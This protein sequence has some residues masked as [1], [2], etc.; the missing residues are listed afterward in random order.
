MATQGNLA[1]AIVRRYARRL[2]ARAPAV[3]ARIRL[4]RTV[5]LADDFINEAFRRELRR[6]LNAAS[7]SIP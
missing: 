7:P 2:A 6:V 3:A 5:F 1:D 4:L